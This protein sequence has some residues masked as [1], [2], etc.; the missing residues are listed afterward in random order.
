MG[1]QVG[2]KDTRVKYILFQEQVARD[3]IHYQEVG[4]FCNLTDLGKV[5]DLSTASVWQVL[6]GRRSRNARGY[7]VVR[8]VN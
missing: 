4:K 2:F 3:Q 1:R 5:L 6:N 7:K 8:V